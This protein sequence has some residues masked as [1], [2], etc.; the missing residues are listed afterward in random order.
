[1][2]GDC[3][4]LTAYCLL[5]TAYCLLLTAYCSLLTAH[6]LLPLTFTA[7]KKAFKKFVAVKTFTPYAAK[8]KIINN[9]LGLK[10]K[11]KGFAVDLHRV[12]FAVDFYRVDKLLNL[13][14]FAFIC[15]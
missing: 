8:V 12:I 9:A 4:L 2:N 5:L 13:R 11:I 15:G 7:S 10:P 3:L 14:A 1:V 6:C